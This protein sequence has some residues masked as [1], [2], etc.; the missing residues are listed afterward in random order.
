MLQMGGSGMAVEQRCVGPI[1]VQVVDGPCAAMLV[2]PSEPA[3]GNGDLANSIA[4]RFG[5]PADQAGAG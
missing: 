4:I 1:Q 5:E 3:F 2:N